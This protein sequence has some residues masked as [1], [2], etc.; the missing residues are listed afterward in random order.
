MGPVGTN[1]IEIWMKIQL[2][3]K[4]VI[5]KSIWNGRYLTQP[6]CVYTMQGSFW[7]WAQPMRG[8]NYVATTPLIGGAH[9]QNDPWK[10]GWRKMVAIWQKT[11]S[12]SISWMKTTEF[13]LNRHDFVPVYGRPLLVQI[14]A[15][16]RPGD[17]PLSEPVMVSLLT[18]ICVTRPR[19]VNWPL[20]LRVK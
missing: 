6:R 2:S 19:W 8:V 10:W 11:F 14:M 9:T 15:W 7:L 12:N 18:H 1:F 20:V 16:R 17:K 3:C 5:L 13:S 4:K